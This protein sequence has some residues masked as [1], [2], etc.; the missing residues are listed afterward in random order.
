MSEPQPWCWKLGASLSHLL[1]CTY[2]CCSYSLCFVVIIGLCDCYWYMHRGMVSL[3]WRFRLSDCFL[4]QCHSGTDIAVLRSVHIFLY[5]IHLCVIDTYTHIYLDMSVSHCCT[6]LHISVSFFSLFK[7]CANPLIGA[8]GIRNSK[9]VR[10]VTRIYK[11]RHRNQD[12]KIS[13]LSLC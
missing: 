9:L 12:Q 10:V 1:V 11:A 13:T 3:G 7:Y 8:H 5:F 4:V 6:I 2:D